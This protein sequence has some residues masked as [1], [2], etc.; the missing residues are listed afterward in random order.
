[1]AI[2]QTQCTVFKLNLLKGLENFTATSPYVYKIA[3]Y[4]GNANLGSSTLTYTTDRKST[5]LNSSH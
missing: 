3:L 4:N 1:M 5:R 2:I